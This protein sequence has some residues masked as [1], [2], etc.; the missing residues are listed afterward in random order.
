MKLAVTGRSAFFLA[1]PIILATAPFG[2]FAVQQAARP[3]T[4][5]SALSDPHPA[6]SAENHA[7]PFQQRARPCGFTVARTVRG[8]A[9]NSL[10]KLVAKELWLAKPL[11]SAISEIERWHIFSSARSA[12]ARSSR[13][14]RM[15]VLTD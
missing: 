6:A 1:R 2:N 15:C 4:K 14:A 10:L 13:L 7:L 5:P 3:R 12:R 8:D 9:P 11:R